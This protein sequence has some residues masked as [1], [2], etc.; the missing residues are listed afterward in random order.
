ML[1]VA[2]ISAPAAPA[3]CGGI[4]NKQNFSAAYVGSLSRNAATDGADSAAYNPAGLTYLENGLYLELDAQPFTFDYGHEID[5]QTYSASPVLIA[6][7]AF[8]VFKQNKLALWGAFTIN[9][10]G[11][12]T[13]Y[14][15]GNIIT[16]MIGNA[17]SAGAFSPYIP[18]DYTLTSPYAFAESYAY[19]FT[20]GTAYQ[21]SDLF[22]LAA[23]I[24]YVT[25]D[26]K[27]D[28]H[29]TYGPSDIISKYQQ[30]A[31]GFGG[32]FGLDIHPSDTLN[33]GIRYETRINLDWDTTT[34]GSNASGLVLLSMFNREAGKSY[35]R[36]LPAVLALGLEY[37]AT[38]KLT[39]KPSFS[40]YFEE[41]ADWGTQNYAVDGNSWDLGL[42]LQYDLNPAW[43]FTVGY[44]YIDVDMK[45]E[46]FGIIEMMNPPLDC[47]AFAVGTR[48]RA[49][50]RLT[51]TLSTSGYFY[52]DDSSKAN[53]ATGK[54]AVTYDKTIY[55]GAIGIQYRFR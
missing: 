13:E 1:C 10:G 40:L 3:F 51:L 32:I 11:G 12:E 24:R 53:P 33:I 2:L 55:Q 34:N 18:G 4:D 26:K 39:V 36:D 22:S 35:A 8:A 6:P 25:T 54:P 44:M 9:G 41:D 46:N 31:D 30:E 38:D 21:I 29:G 49:T 20:A 5:S 50:D 17:L 16:S 45:P 47:H 23:G 19:T 37:K 52:Q 27:V 43:S 7:T 28:I 42:A 48:Y 14:E 15:S